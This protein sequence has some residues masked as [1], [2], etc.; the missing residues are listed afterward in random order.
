VGA[1]SF[2]LVFD[3]GR[4]APYDI[5]E[6]RGKFVGSLWLG[7]E[8]LKW[9]LQTWDLLRQSSELKG[10]FRFKRTEYSTLE[11]SCLQNHRGR[12]VELCKYHGGAQRSGIRVPEGY[13]GK[14]WNRFVVELQSFFLCK[15]PPVELKDGKS[16]NGKK[17]PNRMLLDSS[18]PP[19]KI[20]HPAGAV[21]SSNSVVLNMLPRVDLD[22]DAIRLTRK[23]EFTWNLRDKML[24]ITKGAEGLK[25]KAQGLIQL[26]KWAFPQAQDHAQA[27]GPFDGSRE[28]VR[29]DLAF[30]HGPLDGSREP[31][32]PEHPQVD[33]SSSDIQVEDLQ[34]KSLASISSDEEEPASPA[35]SIGRDLEKPE[36]ELLM[37]SAWVDLASME[38]VSGA[39]VMAEPPPFFDSQFDLGGPS[40]WEVEPTGVEGGSL[41]IVL[42]NDLDG[43]V[44]SPFQCVPLATVGPPGVVDEAV[45]LGPEPSQWV[46]WRH[47]GFCKLVG[48]P[49][50]RY[51]TECL[52]LLQ[53]IE[54]DRFAN[55][56]TSVP[57]RN[58][59]SGTKGK[60]ELR[61]LM[62]SVNYE[63]RQP[64]C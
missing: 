42:V 1:K 47:R 2:F 43:E 11:L 60:R 45:E 57:R 64:V 8:N 3:G 13:L 62:S 19:A 27:Q 6:K 50:E 35:A 9:L 63:G 61:G 30:T 36:V 44:T 41:P 4:T 38:E 29:L 52:A 17:I 53:R 56:S 23:C 22:L 10:F 46:K 40:N 59:A 39:M 55:K 37:T 14:G 28:P 24:R 48:F 54:A 51:E 49:I 34:V 21:T 12:F 18:D 26:D 33:I 7:L 32:R 20:S 15:Q 5:I 31:V 16:R 58:R 25:Y